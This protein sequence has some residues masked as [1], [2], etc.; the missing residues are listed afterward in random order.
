MAANL[1][2]LRLLRQLQ[3]QDRPAEAEE[4]TVLA[5][6]SG[7]GAVPRIFDEAA[8]DFAAERTQLKT[9]LDERE[10]RAASRTTLNAHY[11]DA[12]IASAM[13]DMV[14]RAGFGKD[15]PTRVLEPGCGAGTFLGLAPDTA[16]ALIGVELDPVT[17]AIAAKLYPHADIRAQSFAETRIPSASIDL[18][19]GNVPFGK[20]AL[21]DKVHNPNGHSLHNHFILKSLALT[22]PGGVVAVLTSHYTMDATNPAAR[23]E[24]AA[25][26]DLV[27]AVRLPMSAHQRAAGTRSSPTSSCCAAETRARNRQMP[28]VG[29][30][31]PR[32]AAIPSGRCS[33]T[34]TSPN[35]PTWSSAP[36]ASVRDSS[37]PNWRSKPHPTLTSPDS[38][39]PASTT[40]CARRPP[41]AE[42]RGRCSASPAAPVPDAS[43]LR[44]DA[45]LDA[46]ERH[47]A[48]GDRWPFSI[49]IDG[50]LHEHK[51]PASQAKELTALLGLRD[52]T[53]ALL[54]AE[55]GN[56]EDTEH[57][58]G[59]RRLLNRQYDTYTAQ[60]GPINRITYR[61]TG[62]VNEITGE[63]RLARISPPQ[64]GFRI[65]PRS[66]AVYA[67][68]DFDAT[69]GTARKAPI[70]SGRVVAP[71]T[72]RLGA[73]TPADAV[74]ICLDTHG[75]V[76]LPEVARLLGRSEQDTRTAITGLVFSDP[77]DPERLVPAP[78]YLSGNVRVKLHAAEL[79]AEREAGNRW[80]TNITALREVIPTDLS[81]A[82]IDAR[83]GA[84][85]IDGDVV[86][87]FL[88]E[89]LADPSVRVEH[90]GGSTWAVRGNSH[91]VLATSTFGT[92]RMSAIDI[93]AALLEQRQIRIADETPDGHRI[94]NLTETV[95]AQEKA[96]ELSERFSDW[97]WAEP[98]R[99]SVLTRRYNDTF[100]AIV[101][102]T[103]DGA[104]MQLPGLTLS[105]TPREHQLAA[106]ARIVSE[107]SV[108]LAHEVG[109][110]K[111]AE[112]V[113]GAHELRRMGMATK[114]AVVVPNHMLEQFSR[115]WMQ[116]YPQA[117][118][119][120]ATIEDLGKTNADA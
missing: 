54:S 12:A 108:L 93:A 3:E 1:A 24:I 10:W 96:S 51:V 56:A 55:A 39:A 43:I 75:Q 37:V 76:H 84:S 94:P 61:R 114:P 35:T 11:T 83:L 22:R 116:L 97:I 32:S 46:Q 89:T 44:P 102:R 53:A 41:P 47:I 30:P 29:R 87:Q 81:P 57:I 28:A 58:D 7:W 31:P 110:G 14:E 74:A 90:P 5:R 117:R 63:D 88:R 42:R 82:E 106:V 67:L 52:T 34:A 72:P 104:D 2:A 111:T 70:M 78:E 73:D 107:P 8:E 118:I 13:W 40:G 103:Y 26:A 66:P 19:I 119:L 21:H 48:V 86:Q 68:E 33:S 85:W 9:L 69:V 92:T 59:L 99:A 100:N 79:A 71:R 4:Q 95:A 77:E 16:T 15:G 105:F 112:M 80:D 50:Q 45:P 6:W 49:V 91:T 38:C 101:L 65:D 27:A 25:M 17:A 18:V 62:R 36:P 115:E 120:G 98:E 113:I 64:G 20:V 109:A 60:W 23:R